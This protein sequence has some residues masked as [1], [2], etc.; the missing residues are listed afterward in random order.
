M[1][2]LC[3]DFYEIYWSLANFLK[4]NV[5]L[6]S[7]MEFVE[8]KVEIVKWFQECKM[9]KNKKHN[10]SFEFA[11]KKI[12]ESFNKFKRWRLAMAFSFWSFELLSTKAI[13]LAKDVN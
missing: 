8:P 13:G 6:I 3:Q 7:K 9:K 1:F 10:V 11:S 12:D 2:V 4:T 5:K